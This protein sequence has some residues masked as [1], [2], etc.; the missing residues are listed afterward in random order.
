M[1]DDEPGLPDEETPA[2]E[3]EYSSERHKKP[4]KRTVDETVKPRVIP[5]FLKG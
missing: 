1:I 2:P 4:R 3:H 5:V